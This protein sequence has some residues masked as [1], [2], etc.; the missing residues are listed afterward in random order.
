MCVAV[1][2]KGRTSHLK[3]RSRTHLSSTCSGFEKMF[4]ACRI[5]LWTVLSAGGVTHYLAHSMPFEVGC[6]HPILF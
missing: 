6:N 5:E 4:R 3:K 1:L 2:R